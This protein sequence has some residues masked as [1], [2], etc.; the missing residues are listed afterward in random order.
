MIGCGCLPDLLTPPQV[1]HLFDLCLHQSRLNPQETHIKPRSTAMAL[2]CKSSD[3]LNRIANGLLLLHDRR[4]R[5]KVIHGTTKPC[6]SFAMPVGSRKRSYSS[7]D[8]GGEDARS[9]GNTGVSHKRPKLDSEKKTSLLACPFW[10]RDPLHYMDCL[11]FNL[12]R[13]KDVKQHLQ[14]KHYQHPH[15]YST[16]GMDLESTTKGDNYIRNPCT[17][18]ESGASTERIRPEQQKKLR[19]IVSRAGSS[20]ADTWFQ[21]WH[22][23]FEDAPL[24]GSP[25]QKTM[26]EEAADVIKTIWAQHKDDITQTIDAELPSSEAL[27]R[28]ILPVVLSNTLHKLFEKLE[29]AISNASRSKAFSSEEYDPASINASIASDRAPFSPPTPPFLAEDYNRLS[30]FGV[31]TDDFANFTSLADSP[32]LQYDASHNFYNSRFLSEDI[33]YNGSWCSNE[34]YLDLNQFLGD[35]LFCQ[36][37]PGLVEEKPTLVV[38]S[39]ANITDSLDKTH[40]DQM[41]TCQSMRPSEAHRGKDSEYLFQGK[42]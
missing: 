32:D 42:L 24:P 4:R 36:S 9:D 22:I 33:S 19:A 15:K 30:G 38:G 26:I 11:G 1:Q 27:P 21:I 6:D 29:K 14:R 25:Y 8:D 17:G 31:Q 41:I 16:L 13:L 7:D 3:F 34:L 23:L 37:Q 2:R 35:D 28:Q 5:L 40:Y 39:F 20:E 10:K 12:K 18:A